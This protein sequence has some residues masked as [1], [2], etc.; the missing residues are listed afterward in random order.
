MRSPFDEGVFIKNNRKKKYVLTGKKVFFPSTKP[1]NYYCSRFARTIKHLGFCLGKK[2]P[3][4]YQL[5]NSYYF[6]K[7][8]VLLFYKMWMYLSYWKIVYCFLW[9]FP[10]RICSYVYLIRIV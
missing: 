2:A 5:I 4:F 3:L 9:V 10:K 8:E 1:S 6:E 7:N